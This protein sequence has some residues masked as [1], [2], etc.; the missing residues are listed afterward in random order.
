[1][2]DH[3]EGSLGIFDYDTS[4]FRV[5]LNDSVEEYNS[6]RYVG[7]ETDGRKIFLP[8]GLVS[9]YET[10]KGCIYLLSPPVLHTGLVNANRMFEG[11]EFMKEAP[12]LPP[13][14]LYGY[15]MFK[16]CLS[17]S[18]PPVIH[19]NME[20]CNHMFDDCSDVIQIA[21]KWNLEHRGH[22][23]PLQLI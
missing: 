7:T 14:L 8:R 21:G 19:E 1:M 5:I 20:I 13:S 18:M 2:I 4:L 16:G 11:C 3:Y 22:M 12:L 15:E 9:G 10:F 23:Y 6:L 17:L